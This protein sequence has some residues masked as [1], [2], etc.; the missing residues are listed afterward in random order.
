MSH[1]LD[2][3]IATDHD[4]LRR[5]AQM[6]G[7]AE[8]SIIEDDRHR[9]AELFAV[10]ANIVDRI[11]ESDVDG[12]DPEIRSG[13]LIDVLE[14][15]ASRCRQDIARQELPEGPKGAWHLVR[16]RRRRLRSRVVVSFPGAG[17][18]QAAWQARRIPAG[19][20]A[21]VPGRSARLHAPFL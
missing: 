20:V 8:P 18:A 21:G 5:D 9:D 16:G 1:I 19:S 3:A 15:R 2:T 13:A 14:V 4:M 11:V 10:G 7:S 6:K 17:C 12:D